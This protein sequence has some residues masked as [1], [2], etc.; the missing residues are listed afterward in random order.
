MK[1]VLIF[2]GI[3]GLAAW[4]V[5]LNLDQSRQE[6]TIQDYA[7]TTWYDVEI[8]RI[9]TFPDWTETDVVIDT[10]RYKR[11]IRYLERSDIDK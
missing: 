10:I 3:I 6:E 11:K 4:I 1:N 9:D 5:Y 2:S 8:M 7:D